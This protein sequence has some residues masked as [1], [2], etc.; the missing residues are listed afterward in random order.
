MG[1]KG[2]QQAA[3]LSAKNAHILADGLQKKGY[4]VL[5]KDF[6]NEFILEIDNADNFLSKMKQNGILA[7]YK[8]DTKQILVCCTEIIT[9]EE[10]EKY[11]NCA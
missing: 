1:K 3:Y 9:K 6:F 7:G 10:I 5:N 2:T 4:N 11:I 8:L